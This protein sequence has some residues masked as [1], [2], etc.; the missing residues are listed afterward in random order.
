MLRS[1]TTPATQSPDGGPYVVVPLIMSGYA[2]ELEHRVAYAGTA[3]GEFGGRMLAED[4][5]MEIVGRDYW[6]R[7]FK[8]GL[9]EHMPMDEN[10]KMKYSMMAEDYV[11]NVFVGRASEMARAEP[12]MV[13][14]LCDAG[15]NWVEYYFQCADQARSAYLRIGSLVDPLL[16]DEERVARFRELQAALARQQDVV[17][18]KYNLHPMQ[19]STVYYNDGVIPGSCDLLQKIQRHCD[20]KGI[21]NPRYQIPPAG[22]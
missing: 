5:I 18:K 16:P 1:K 20:P 4:E 21:L 8:V 10:V 2:G 15:F 3:A 12:D 6:D 7:G 17:L 11:S 13:R 9:I 19:S 14:T 22:V